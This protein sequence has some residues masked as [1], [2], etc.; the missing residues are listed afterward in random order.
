MASSWPND[1]DGVLRGL[2]GSLVA[3]AES[4]GL[5]AVNM[6][7]SLRTAATDWA[8]SVLSVTSSMP[9]TQADIAAKV[10]QLI[11]H[12]TVQDV[13]RYAQHVG[14]FLRAKQ[15]LHQ[16]PYGGQIT[17]DAVWVPPWAQ[18]VGNPAVPT[19]Y[20]IRVQRAITVY[21]FKPIQR[22]EWATYEITAPLTSAQDA[23]QQANTLFSA[24]DYNARAQINQ[25]LDYSIE[26]V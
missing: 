9:P 20:R 11:G 6:W 17:G 8:T 21:G 22:V 23:L 18:T 12:V 26:A 19:R 4:G 2:F 10:D 16:I 5:G 25:V 7:S 24:A 1:P 14:A 15:R 3:G 13:N